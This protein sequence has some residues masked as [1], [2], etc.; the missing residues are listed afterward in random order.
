VK[1]Q[2]LGRRYV[3]ADEVRNARSV[4]FLK[5]AR[6]SA[7]PG[8]VGFDQLRLRR[9]ESEGIHGLIFITDL[10]FV[11]IR[12]GCD[13]DPDIQAV[14]TGFSRCKTGPLRNS[15]FSIANLIFGRQTTFH[16][17]FLKK[18]SDIDR[19]TTLPAIFQMWADHPGDRD[20]QWT[21]LIREVKAEY[22]CLSAFT[23]VAH[24]YVG[25]SLRFQKNRLNGLLRKQHVGAI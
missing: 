7:T 8:R 24:Q 18:R 13:G 21:L 2:A 1:S 19:S 12:F 16:R 14:K 4:L 15:I 20:I 6:A 23:V 3:V 25:R 5:P 17:W 10:R 9:H 11:A 22:L